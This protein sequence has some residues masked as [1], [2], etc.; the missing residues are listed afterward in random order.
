MNRTIFFFVFFLTGIISHSR[1]VSL[2]SPDERT[3]ITIETGSSLNL[4]VSFNG[5]P[6]LRIEGIKLIVD[7][8]VYGSGQ[9][10][11]GEKNSAKDS[12]I[13][14]EIRELNRSLHDHY[15]EVLLNFGKETALRV[16]AYDI[17][18]AYSFE[19]TF[20]AEIRIEKEEA[21]FTF[22]EG[23]FVY[24]PEEKSLFSHN[25]RIY[26]YGYADTIQQEAFCSLPVL[27]VAPGGINLLISESGLSDYPGLWLESE[28]NSRFRAKFPGFPLREQ[29][30]NDRNVVVKEYAGYIAQTEGNRTFPWR[31][32]AMAENDKD[33]LSNQL[34]Y[35]LAEPCVLEDPSWIKP[36]KVA[37]DWW[38]ALN[39]YGVDFKAGLNTDTYKYYIDFAAEFGIEYI[40]LDEG[41]YE[42]GDLLKVNEDIDMEEL[43][44]YG[45]AKGV[46]IILWV[47][48]KTLE[49]QWEEAFNKFSEWGVAGLKVDF[50]QRD[51]Q[52]MVNYYERVAAEAAKRHMI[53]DFHGAY[54]PCGLR[55]KYPN[56][57]TR[58]GVRGLEHSKWSSDI[59]PRH[60][61]TIP[62]IRMVAG[63][64]DYTP[65]AML[66]ASEE[67]FHP[68][69]NRPMSMGTRCHQ[70]AMYV[71]YNSPLQMLADSPSN[72]YRERECTEFIAGVPT[73]WDSTVVLDAEIGE[74]I[75][76]A[77]RS[78]D[79]WYVGVMC[80]QALDGYELNL[81]FL[82]DRDYLVTSFSDGPNAG[83]YTGDY[84]IKRE[85]VDRN[86]VL[87]IG[88]AEGGGFIARITEKE[89]NH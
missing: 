39:L 19:T 9:E 26:S 76:L 43:L 10:L 62:F 50:M 61:L 31:F 5:N 1:D 60:N 34:G 85:E 47:V 53:V 36:G 23:T 87:K 67:Q 8:K 89:R 45:K 40:I 32:I 74:F 16:R 82:H 42:L 54:K 72:Y 86:G 63:P 48:W 78:G 17:G 20:P 3:K 55:R 73:V 25:E 83:S 75:A 29:Q 44:E 24:F 56:V 51:D 68:V 57:L 81:S 79:E 18:I 58:E 41:W 12:W 6:V 33:L 49:D 64:M 38:N 27:M 35:L 65:G 15:N 59:T 69:F 70:M 37:W 30:T 7:S 4:L 80:N 13:F 28:G 71:V 11:S 52:W 46:G 66:N 84:K 14:P 77:K 22:P 21:S 2:F 88:L